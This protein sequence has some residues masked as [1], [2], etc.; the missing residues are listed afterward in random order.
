[1]IAHE[2]VVRVGDP[3]T[4]W[5]L[6]GVEERE[7]L[8]SLDSKIVLQQVVCLNAILNEE[9]VA[10]CVIGNVVC[11]SQVPDMMNCNSSVVSVVDRVSVYIGVV[12]CANHVEV[13]GIS[14]KLERLANILKLDVLDS[15][16]QRLVSV[17]AKHDVS[18]VLIINGGRRVA[19]EHNVSCKQADLGAHFDEVTVCKSLDAREVLELKR[20]VKSDHW[21]SWVAVI[22]ADDCPLFSLS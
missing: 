1:M 5:G 16:D 17:R 8:L 10:H 11:H 15:S 22:N 3:E 6:V 12:D 18:T 4:C 20:S 21:S 19:S 7:R 13:D 14:S 9:R 2:D